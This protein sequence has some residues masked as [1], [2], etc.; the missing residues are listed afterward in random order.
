[1]FFSTPSSRLGLRTGTHCILEGRIQA[2]LGFFSL[3]IKDNC[4]NA[5]WQDSRQRHFFVFIFLSFFR[6]LLFLSSFPFFLL[7]PFCLWFTAA[8]AF[9]LWRYPHHANVRSSY[10]R[11]VSLAVRAFD[12]F[13][14]P[15]SSFV[16]ISFAA[17]R[18]LA[19][20]LVLSFNCFLGLVWVFFFGFRNDSR[21]FTTNIPLIRA[22]RKKK[23]GPRI[24]WQEMVSSKITSRQ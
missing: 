24:L 22:W 9:F 10:R 16:H 15:F 6:Y 17:L 1:M 2:D 20:F 19:I 3:F 4:S 5:V 14:L 8:L 12:S 13:L 11:R 7:S 23:E 21:P 18:G